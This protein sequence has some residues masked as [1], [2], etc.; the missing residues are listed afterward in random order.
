[1]CPSQSFG[2]APATEGLLCTSL[3]ISLDIP[4]MF[5][6]WCCSDT[7]GLTPDVL[8]PLV[9]WDGSCAA[10]GSLL[11]PALIQP[12]LEEWKGFGSF[13][14]LWRRFRA[15]QI[16]QEPFEEAQGSQL[17]QEPLQMHR[18]F[19]C[20]DSH[21][22]TRFNPGEEICLLGDALRSCRGWGP[23][24]IHAGRE[25]CEISSSLRSY[26]C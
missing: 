9:L 19:L 15:P 12:C 7:S 4:W 23:L 25:F 17:L 10:P 6:G 3:G 11:L 21:L 2:I 8:Q 22:L 20:L 5:L 16:L 26:P 18:S 14:S 13:R 1:M 24:S